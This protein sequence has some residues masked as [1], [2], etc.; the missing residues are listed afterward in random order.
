MGRRQKTKQN[1]ISPSN[2]QGQSKA[3]RITITPTKKGLL[4]W[5]FSFTISYTRDG[6]IS[7]TV[8]KEQPICDISLQ[9]NLRT[10]HKVKG[11]KKFGIPVPL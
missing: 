5:C 6:Y 8:E 9:S 7:R 3:K 4:L 1:T 10:A 2:N 11:L